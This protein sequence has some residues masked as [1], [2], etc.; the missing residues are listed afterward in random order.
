MVPTSISVGPD[1]AITS[2]IRN[3]PPI[4]TSWP[5]ETTIA[6]PGPASA[7]AASS[8]AAG[9]VVDHDRASA[10]VSSRSSPATWSCRLPRSPVSRS[11]SRLRV[12]RGGARPPPRGPRPAA[13]RGPRLVWTIT[14]VALMT[15]R[16]EG[17]RGRRPAAARARGRLAGAGRRPAGAARCSSIAR[18]AA[19]TA[20]ACGASSCGGQLVDRR[21][22]PQLA[23]AASA[24]THSPSSFFQIGAC[25][26][27]SSMI[28]RAPGE[29]LV[30]VGRRDRDG[31]RGLRQRDG[32]DPVLGG[33]GAQAVALD[34]RARRSRP[35]CARPSRRRP[36]SRAAATSRV[37]PRNVTTAPARG[38]RTRSSSGSS[39]SGSVGHTDVRRRR[40]SR[41]DTGGI[42]ASSSPACE[43]RHRRRRTRG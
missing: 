39:A 13:G 8:T 11:S 36:R 24:G 18:R 42:S 14:P 22:R 26:L 4:S 1:W 15:R 33:G 35:S 38:S 2:G 16:S 9:A 17:A 29:R 43:L 30:A 12:A 3:P 34:R 40:P 27:I 31:D 19:A 28:S 37:T 21:Q 5:R 20:R 6:R 41:P 23:R 25:A 7:A 10:P 32:A